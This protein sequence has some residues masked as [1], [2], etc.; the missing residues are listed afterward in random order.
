MHTRLCETPD[1]V[2]IAKHSYGVEAIPKVGRKW[3]HFN[4]NKTNVKSFGILLRRGIASA[5]STEIG[6]QSF[7]QGLA[8]TGSV[9]DPNLSIVGYFVQGLSKM[10]C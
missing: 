1:L 8:M 9:K 2:R 7:K 4:Y 6:L 3:M 10:T 5:P